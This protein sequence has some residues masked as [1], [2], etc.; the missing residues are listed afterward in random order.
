[1]GTILDRMAA[2]GTISEAQRDRAKQAPLRFVV[3]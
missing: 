3:E 2:R 1:M